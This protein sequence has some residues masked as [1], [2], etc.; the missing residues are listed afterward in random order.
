MTRTPPIPGQ[1]HPDVAIV[2]SALAEIR[3][4]DVLPYAEVAKTLQLPPDSVIFRRRADAAR[5]SLEGEQIVIS[6]VTGVGFL[7]ELG[8][9]TKD[10]VAGRETRHLQRK[11][12]RNVRQLSSIDVS[13]IPQDQRAELYGLM[14]VNRAVQVVTGKP[15]R[16]KLTAACTTISAELAVAKALE[17]LQERERGNGKTAE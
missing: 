8:T 4:G 5:K 3:P 14:T 9:Q 17:V 12:R 13:K 10:R 2:K 6:C 15:S 7:R 11:A 16:L 1:P